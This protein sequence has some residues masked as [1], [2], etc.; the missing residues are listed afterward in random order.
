MSEQDPLQRLESLRSQGASRLDPARFRYLEALSRRL[1]SQT[2][3]VRLLLQ[4]KLQVA[5]ADYARRFA[6]EQQVQGISGW[7]SCRTRSGI[8]RR[9]GLRVK[10]AMTSVR[11]CPRWHS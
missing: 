8:H 1:P 4:D 2:E 3:P 9:H 7:L 10:P 5:L 6:Q 11:R